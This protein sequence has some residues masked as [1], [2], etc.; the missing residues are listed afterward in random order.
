MADGRGSV[1]SQRGAAG[2]G[3]D[4]HLDLTVGVRPRRPRPPGGSTVPAARAASASRAEPVGVS[5][6]CLELVRDL[7]ALRRRDSV[8]LRR[9]VDDG[10][11]AGRSPT[12]LCAA[13]LVRVAA[14]TRDIRNR[15]SGQRRRRH[16]PSADRRRI[17]EQRPIPL[18]RESLSAS[19]NCRT[20]T[21]GG[22]PGTTRPLPRGRVGASVRN[23]GYRAAVA[24]RAC[25]RSAEVGRPAARRLPPV[26]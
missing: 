20:R 11:T 7:G 13:L 12:N 24:P 23:R 21:V 8:P 9:Q 10:P 2:S 17:L 4:H 19:T 15:A 5:V 18:R 3:T 22:A 6:A 16:H 26:I 1:V 14:S 25:R